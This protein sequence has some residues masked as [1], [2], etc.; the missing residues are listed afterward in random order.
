MAAPPPFTREV[1]LERHV[2]IGRPALF[3]VTRC[4]DVG[5]RRMHTCCGERTSGAMATSGLDRVGF[6]H[7]RA[8]G[9]R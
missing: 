1:G 3:V 7:G 6:I 4:T 5:Y 9:G 8:V 2:N